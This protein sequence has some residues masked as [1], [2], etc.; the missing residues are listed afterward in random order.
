MCTTGGMVDGPVCPAVLAYGAVLLGNFPYNQ[1]RVV[2]KAVCA[3][4]LASLICLV[5]FLGLLMIYRERMNR[6]R[7]ECRR[8]VIKLLEARPGRPHITSLR[9]SDLG[10]GYDGVAQSGA[11]I[12][13]TPDGFEPLQEE[14]MLGV[15]ETSPGGNSHS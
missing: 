8:L 15:S 9:H 1:A 10:A 14:V 4:G 12:N 11:E 3:V 13:G 6:L 7:E 2:I 5:S